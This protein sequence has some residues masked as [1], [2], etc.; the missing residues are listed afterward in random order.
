MLER[1]QIVRAGQTAWAVIGIVVVAA[2]VY[3]ALQRVAVLTVPLLLALFPAAALTPAV[4]WLRARRMPSWLAAAIAEIGALAV[5]GGLIAVAV[6]LL[7]DELPSLI[8]SVTQSFEQLRSMLQGLPGVPSDTS[9]QAVGERLLQRFTQ[10]DGLSSALGITANVVVGLGGVVLLLVALFFFLFQGKWL[11]GGVLK[12]VPRARREAATTLAERI[13]HT[14]GAY[15]RSLFLIAVVDAVLIGIGLAL[16]GV[17]VAVPLA[18][19]VFFGGFFPYVGALVSGLV[20]VLVAF[21]DGG[22]GIALAAAGVVVGVQALEGNVLEPL[23]AGRMVRLPAFVVIIAIT[24]GGALLGVFGAFISV[25]AAAA[26][27]RAGEFAAEREQPEQPE[28]E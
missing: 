6:P 8:D 19:L 20:A 27:A 7:L 23:I 3:Y 18:L 2:A 24:L 25:P 15:F 21:A 11:A 5:I 14:I 26:V 1:N 12:L 10:G 9:P 16:L 17:P 22:L 28:P 4:A 13:W